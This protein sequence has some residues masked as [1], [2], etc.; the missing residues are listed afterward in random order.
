MKRKTLIQ[1]RDEDFTEC[2][3]AAARRLAKEDARATPQQIIDL[4]MNAR[5]KRYYISFATIAQNIMRRRRTGYCGATHGHEAT[6]EQ[7][8]DIDLAVRRYMLLHRG[9][10]ITDAITHVANFCRPSRF[11]IPPKRA[12]ALFRQ[13]LRTE[14]RIAL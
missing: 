5:P 3:C 2:L 4:A 14:Y 11:F 7:W 13:A 9:A 6:R 12:R 1:L 10:T 8:R